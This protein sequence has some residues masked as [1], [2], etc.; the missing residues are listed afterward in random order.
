M[1]GLSW[2]ITAPLLGLAWFAAINAIVSVVSLMLSR[3]FDDGVH[4]SVW[5]AR[6]LLAVRLA[7]AALSIT[8]ALILFLPA[9][10]WLEPVRPD[11]RIGVVPMAVAAGAL[12]LLLRSVWRTAAA[13]RMAYRLSA[14]RAGV[15]TRH[16]TMTLAE[17]PGLRGI[18]LAG[19]FRP[20]ILI[21]TGAREI[22]TPGELDLA[23]AH[24]R[25]HHR[26]WDNL[27][28][29]V[30]QCA[31]DFF[32]FSREARRLEA[33]WEAEAECLAD[34][35]AVAGSDARATRLA[36]ALVKVARLASD[37]DT[38]L[39][40]WSTFHH[41]ALLEARVRLLVSD[42]PVRPARVYRGK[43]AAAFAVTIV[44]A[45]W[46]AG[47]PQQIHRLTESLLAL[48]P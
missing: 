16:A 34:A 11:E 28:R 23:I 2:E 40:G 25:A 36:S 30:M 29:T 19:I 37:E 32:G 26:A 4:A 31:P 17:V 12:V 46:T 24:E 3:R 41:P 18:A 48:L 1:T 43:T 8:I 42:T 10:V 27:S 7:P 38:W 15:R 5:R 14:L 45:A 33:L 13:I 9:H 39:A 6:R 22:L 35:A 20:R 44:A 21:G 47:L